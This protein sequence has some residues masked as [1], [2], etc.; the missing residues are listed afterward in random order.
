ME[1]SKP[2]LS[3]LKV[4]RRQCTTHDVEYMP[5]KV[6]GQHST[7]GPIEIPFRHVLDAR[8]WVSEHTK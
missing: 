6:T 5:W 7:M 4:E 8:E 3:G 2:T 1:T